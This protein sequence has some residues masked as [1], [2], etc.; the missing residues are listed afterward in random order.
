[1]TPTSQAISI[2]HATRVWLPLTMTWLYNQLRHLPDHI[3]NHVVCE[4]VENRDAFFFDAITTCPSGLSR[5]SQRLLRIFG[6]QSFH[7]LLNR[8]IAQYRP[9]VVHSHFGHVGWENTKIAHNR[10]LAHVVT[11][12]GLDM[13]MLPVIQPKWKQRYRYMFQVVDQVICEGRHMAANLVALGYPEHKIRVIPIGIDLERISFS[14]RTLEPGSKPRFLIVGA[15]REKK[16]IP[17]AIGALGRLKQRGLEFELTVI[18]DATTENRDI[19]EKRRIQVAVDRWKLS[20]QVRFLGFQ[21]YERI[22]QEFYRHHIFL[23][24]SRTAANGDTEGGAPVTIIEAAA[25]GMPVISTTHCDIPNVLGKSNRQRLVRE[26]D[27]GALAHA[28]DQLTASGWDRLVRENRTFIEKQHDIRRSAQAIA[29]VYADV[30][31][32]S[33]HNPSI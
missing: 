30:L 6:F 24:P 31:N 16:G 13:N 26:G 21:P 9:R 5:W 27:E 7:P 14:P 25:S 12:Y 33:G 29:Q 18:G 10:D 32:S 15:F 4:R 19:L 23:S 20:G 1:M 28:I 17:D 8:A 11:F 22:L 3:A 2:V